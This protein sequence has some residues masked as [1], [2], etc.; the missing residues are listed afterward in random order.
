MYGVK[1]QLG[2]FEGCYRELRLVE[3]LE[4]VIVGDE[5]VV[6]IWLSG[7]KDEKFE[8]WADYFLIP[9]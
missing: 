1:G 3:I 7:R 5:M 6:A 2:H 4:T 8:N 9:V